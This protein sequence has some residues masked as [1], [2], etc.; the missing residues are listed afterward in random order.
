MLQV[1]REW[2]RCSETEK[3]CGPECG[4]VVRV[5]C[6]YNIDV[7]KL[8]AMEII[9]VCITHRGDHGHQSAVTVQP[10]L[11]ADAELHQS[12][13]GG[14]RHQAGHERGLG[15]ESEISELRTF[16]AE[17]RDNSRV[18]NCVATLETMPGIVQHG[19][20]HLNLPPD[21]DGR[22][23]LDPLGGG[24]DGQVLRVGVGGQEV[25]EDVDQV[26][27]EERLLGVLP[28]RHVGDHGGHLVL[29]VDAGTDGAGEILEHGPHRVLAG[30]GGQDE[31][32]EEGEVGEGR[33]AEEECLVTPG[34]PAELRQI[35]DQIECILRHAEHVV[36][37][38]Y[39]GARHLGQHP[40]RL[41]PLGLRDGE[42]TEQL[43]D[44][45]HSADLL[46][47]P[48]GLQDGAE[49]GEGPEGGGPDGPVVGGGEEVDQ[50]RHGAVLGHQAT[51]VVPLQAQAGDAHQAALHLTHRHARTVEAGHDLA[52]LAA[53]HF[54]HQHRD[55]RPELGGGLH[56]LRQVT[57]PHVGSAELEIMD[58]VEDLLMLPHDHTVV[59]RVQ[60]LV[61]LLP[62]QPSGE[63]EPGQVV[64]VP[65]L[66]AGRSD[67]YID[68]LID[69][70]TSIIKFLP[71]FRNTIEIDESL[72]LI[73]QILDAPHYLV[74][75]DVAAQHSDNLNILA[76]EQKQEGRRMR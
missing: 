35:V 25:E 5:E 65:Q 29:D 30:H 73:F 46:Q 69:R 70:L 45:L 28:G 48:D 43:G 38:L 27:G 13:Q 71:E 42:V 14:P 60:H 61:H 63:P 20:T 40:G 68:Q 49:G 2:R 17:P 55:A 58:V 21:S 44:D 1:C 4:K 11:L 3:S 72:D 10:R 66:A 54:L 6:E 56:H 39:P 19:V 12:L 59:L 7:L 32:G 23:L 75:P 31:R 51:Q 36:V 62:L 34:V 57:L 41:R 24:Q 67:N 52:H 50:E 64:E 47:L 37:V 22:L 26:T 16:G 8:N 18:T 76:T 74:F 9:L 53:Q 15:R 33:G